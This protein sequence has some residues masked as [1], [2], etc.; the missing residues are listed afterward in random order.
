MKT[1]K[2]EGV[3][4][5]MGVHSPQNKKGTTKPDYNGILFIQFEDGA[6]I[7]VSNKHIKIEVS[8]LTVNK[9]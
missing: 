9:R 3:I 5:A 7:K 8:D 6:E 4:K 1:K 2:H